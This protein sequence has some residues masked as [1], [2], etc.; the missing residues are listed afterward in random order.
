M[1]SSS[2]PAVKCLSLP[3]QNAALPLEY[4]VGYA[5]DPVTDASIVQW[6][7]ASECWRGWVN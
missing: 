1:L 4:M 7:R 5:Q 3:V 6:D 2:V